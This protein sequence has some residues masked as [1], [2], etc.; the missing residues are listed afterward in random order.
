[1][2]Q[3]HSAISR[4]GTTFRA[5]KAFAALLAALL[6][7][8]CQGSSFGVGVGMGGGSGTRVGVGVGAGT[9]SVGVGAGGFG[10]SLNSYGDFLNNGPNEAYLNNK[11]GIKQ[12]NDGNFDAARKIFTDTLEKYPDLP[13]STYYLG[14]T[15]IYQGEREAGF[16]LLKTYR[17]PLYYRATSAVQ[18]MAAYLEKKPEL[19]AEKI[20]KTMNKERREGFDWD[21]RERLERNR[22][23]W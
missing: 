8:G 7:A 22:D 4:S 15:L 6:L 19:T 1:M 18:R 14:L 23:T 10:V 12:L 13:D 20:H 17:E 3:M 21:R 11:A 9:T 16:G 5:L 2:K